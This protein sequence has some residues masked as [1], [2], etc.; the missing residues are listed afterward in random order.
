MFFIH[1]LNTLSD[2][3][4]DSLFAPPAAQ[5]ASCVNVSFYFRLVI[6]IVAVNIL[7]IKLFIARMS[8]IKSLRP[9]LM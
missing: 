2:A 4:S 8:R 9:S 1:F 5:S 6:N 7:D 3:R